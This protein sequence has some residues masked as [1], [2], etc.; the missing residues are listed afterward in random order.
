[1]TEEQKSSK[2]WN[3]ILDL[4]YDIVGT[5][6]LSISLYSFSSPNHIA[7]GGV[8]GLAIII[9]YLTG[10]PIGT[11]SLGMNIPLL[12][13]AWFLLGRSFTAKTLKTVLINTV[14]LD[15]LLVSLHF[16]IYEGNP[17]LAALFGGGLAGIGL[18]IVFLRGSSTGGGDIIT[19][20][21]QLKLPHLQVGRIMFM[22]D[23]V[24]LVISAL[25]YR[26]IE[27]ALF[28]MISIYTGSTLINSV[29]YGVDKGRMVMIVS[30]DCR[31][32]AK[33]I[34]HE[35]SRGST[36]L[37]GIGGYSGQDKQVL[38]CAVRNSQFPQLKTLVLQMDPQ[39]FVIVM[40]ASEVL[41]EGFKRLD[42]QR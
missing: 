29:L 22:I 6:L 10:L 42:E 38:I 7:P 40:E 23:C 13:S 3:I 21:I 16:P 30:D 9:N 17:I 8:S 35:L 5:G 24:V 33:G 37:K 32:I 36:I 31:K 28:G 39:A 1:M 14:I 25:A 19:R 27:S 15:I 20:L 34:S 18:G 12:I 2:W 11:L 26:S 4:G 41:G